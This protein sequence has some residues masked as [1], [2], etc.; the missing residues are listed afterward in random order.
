MDILIKGYG[1]VGSET[2]NYI[3]VKGSKDYGVPKLVFED[4]GLGY[5][6][7]HIRYYAVIVCTP[8]KDG[9]VDDI[10]RLAKIP[11][12]HLIIRSTVSPDGLDEV[13]AAMPKD[14]EVHFWPE[15]LTEATARDDTL[16]PDKIV[17]G[18]ESSKQDKSFRKLAEVLGVYQVDTIIVSLE[19][20]S[21]LKLAINSYYTM[22]VVFNN[23]IYD[24]LK[25]NESDY[26][27]VIRSMGY[28]KRITISHYD[29]N[30]GGY[31][32]AGGKCLPKD[33]RNLIAYLNN[34]DLPED[35]EVLQAIYNR[36]EEL[37]NG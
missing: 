18:T 22:K 4:P 3:N 14:V 5:N 8:C 6:P 33:T 35:A 24:A 23:I 16:H 37:R 19:S 2:A 13:K 7:E 21:I 12:E 17:L 34:N 32:G 9:Y 31:R 10:D 25:Q 29:I 20:A 15:F 26:E 30:Q 36:N 27:N 11:M 28:D 1:I